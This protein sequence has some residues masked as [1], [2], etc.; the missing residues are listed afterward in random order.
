METDHFSGEKNNIE[1]CYDT[2]T[3]HW[4]DFADWTKDRI[5]AS[6]ILPFIAKQVA[7]IHREDPKVRM[8]ILLIPIN[9]MVKN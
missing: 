1:P 5:P 9:A 4:W 3:L 8:N 6:F 2:S 7:V